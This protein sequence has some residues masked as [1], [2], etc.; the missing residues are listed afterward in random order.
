M[1]LP[2]TLYGEDLVNGNT[3]LMTQSMDPSVLTT[4][5]DNGMTEDPDTLSLS[6]V[7]LMTQSADCSLLRDN[8]NTRPGPG[9]G[10]GEWAWCYERYLNTNIPSDRAIL[11][12][13]MGD[14]TNPL[15]LQKYI[16]FIIISL[17]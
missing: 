14:S 8:L 16:L 1:E 6:S 2:P 4:G 17:K 10:A 11:L 13:A 3:E 12:S 9:G 15:T 7:D 5:L